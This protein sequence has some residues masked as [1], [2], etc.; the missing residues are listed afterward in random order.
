MTEPVLA[1]IWIAVIAF[2]LLF[3]AIT[4]GADLGVGI[5]SLF[6]RDDR[7]RGVM[8]GGIESTWHTNQTWLVILGGMVFGAFPLF[9]SIVFSALYIPLVSMLFALILRGVALDYRSHAKN[10]PAWGIAFGLGSVLVSI[11][12]GFALGGLLGGIHIESGTFAGSVWDWANPFAATVAAGVVLG[13]TMLGAN[14][15]IL[16]GEGEL[17][18]LGFRYSMTTSLL[19]LPLSIAVY[20]WMLFKYPY[21]VDKF[22]T[23]P[24]LYWVAPAPLLALFSY[25]LLLCSVWMRFEVLPFFLNAAV[26]LFSFA[27]ISIAL[28]PAMIPN[29]ISSP[30]AITDAA[31]SLPVLIFIS[32]VTALILPL[33]LIYNAYNQFWVFRGKIGRYYDEEQ[34]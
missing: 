6:C 11:T 27:G 31:S 34:T 14:F 13:Y 30:V 16:K 20:I 18:R 2:F 22:T 21:M 5:I 8:M 12:Q 29:V 33:I 1:N 25:I 17:Q 24:D 19:V 10:K 9:Y 23:P 28:Y 4:D 15:L 3:Y 7:E 26:I 32:V